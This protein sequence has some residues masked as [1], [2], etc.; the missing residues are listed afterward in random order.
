LHAEKLPPLTA[1]P[2]TDSSNIFMAM[3]KQDILLHLPYQSFNPVLSFFNQAAIDTDV[4]DIYITLYRL[5]SESYIVNALINAAK[6]GKNVVVF[7]ELKARFDEANN[8]KWS[9]I[10]KEAGITLIYSMPQIKVHSKIA[11]VKKKVDNDAL[12]YVI[13]STGNFNEVTAQ[14][15]TDHVLMTCNEKFVSELVLLFGFLEKGHNEIGDTKIKFH[16]LLV[17]QFNL[18]EE[19]EKRINKEIKNAKNGMPARIRIKVNNLEEPAIINLLYKASKA[20]VTVELIVRS[21]CCIVS[22]ITGM[23]EN[24]TVRRIVDRFLEH[25]RLFI[26]GAGDDAVVYMGSADLMTRNLHHRIEVC[27]PIKDPRCKKELLDYFDMQWSD[28][29]KAVQQLPD[30]QYLA[31]NGSNGHKKVNAQASIYQYL[32]Q[33][34]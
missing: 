12:S 21:V 16:E 2:V 22:G 20:G 31:V 23:S 9:R 26:F 24:I 27:A 4:T 32:K 3:A 14:F 29:S 10:M 34:I 28:N 5:A 1:A 13:L 18:A 11:L 15:Y 7:I 33:Q 30:Q 17:S 6:N 25:T 19:L 8:I